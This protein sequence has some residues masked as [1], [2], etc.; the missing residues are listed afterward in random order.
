MLSRY[1]WWRFPA[2]DLGGIAFDDIRVAMDTIEQRIDVGG[3]KVY[4]PGFFECQDIIG[5]LS[6]AGAVQ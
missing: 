3:M 2:W 4:D 6:Q 1:C 5:A